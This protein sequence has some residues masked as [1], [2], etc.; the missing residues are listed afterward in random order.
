MNIREIIAKK[1]DG[2][3]LTNEEIGFFTRGYTDGF[4]P[5]Y[6]AAALLMAMYIK[7]LDDEE[8]GYLTNHMVKSGSTVNLNA[9][10]GVKVDKHS[11]GGVGDKTTLVIAPLVAA[12]GVF[13]PKMSG[14]G[15]GHTGGTIDKLESIPGFNTSLSQ[16]EFIKIVRNVGFAVTGQTAN[17]A[18]AD[19]K[20]YGLRDVTSTVDS[21]PLIASSV[22][23]K[24][25]ASGC[26]GIILD[27]K[28]GSGAFMTDMKQ[29][30]KLSKTMISIGEKAGKRTFCLITDMDV[31]LGNTIGNAL[32]VIEAIETLKGNGPEDFTELCIH[33]AGAML[34]VAGKCNDLNSGRDMIRKNIE[35]QSA[36]K[37]FR[38][39][40]RLQGGDPNVVDDYS[41]FPVAKES[42]LLLSE[43]EGYIRKMDCKKIGITSMELGAGR[44]FLTDVIQFGAGIKLHKKTGDYVNKGDLLATLYSDDMDQLAKGEVLFLESL[45]FAD[46]RPAQRSI[47]K[48]TAD[49]DK[50]EVLSFP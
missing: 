14:R 16:E 46:E 7:G 28:L 26:D 42:K 8:T 27:V 40:V 23:S 29:A 38:E 41:L 37:R 35:N 2:H 15:L 21:I 39:F 13:V 10:K 5:D 18:A 48:A 4:I 34:Y 17:I 11:T 20:I 6:Q 24:K 36:L 22:M 33:I 19:K 49:K 9:I 47:L 12:S 45:E 30:L 44:R 31:P 1:R 32:E 3:T 50:T 25:I 43:T